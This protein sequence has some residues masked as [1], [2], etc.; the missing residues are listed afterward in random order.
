MIQWDV[1][2]TKGQM[3]RYEVLLY[4][5]GEGWGWA[6]WVRKTLIE[7]KA[8]FPDKETAR[9]SVQAAVDRYF[10]EVR[11]FEGVVQARR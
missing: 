6:I 8:N 4:P 11:R 1:S 2:E 7:S 9:T 5:I 3:D 10:D